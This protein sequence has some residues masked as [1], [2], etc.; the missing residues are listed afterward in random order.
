[1]VVPR[2]KWQWG[3][4]YKGATIKYRFDDEIGIIKEEENV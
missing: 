1:M 3:D 2:D 4:I